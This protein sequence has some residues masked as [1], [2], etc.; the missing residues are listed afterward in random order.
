MAADSNFVFN[1][2]ILYKEKACFFMATVKEE[3]IS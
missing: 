3:E 1:F 2:C